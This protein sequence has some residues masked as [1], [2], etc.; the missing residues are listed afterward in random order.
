VPFDANIFLVSSWFLCSSSIDCRAISF[1]C[2]YITSQWSKRQS[3]MATSPP[4]VSEPDSLTRASRHAASLARLSLSRRGTHP[5]Y[6]LSRYPF[7]PIRTTYD[8]AVGPLRKKTSSTKPEILK[9]SQR[10]PMR[11]EPQP[12][13]TCTENLVKFGR[14][15]SEIWMRTDR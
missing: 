10:R 6:R 14:V 4:G 11:N 3:W 12:Q 13:A 2:C 5:R 7:P 9:V 15:F 1:S 8:A